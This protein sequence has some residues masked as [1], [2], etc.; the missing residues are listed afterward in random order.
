LNGSLSAALWQQQNEESLASLQLDQDCLLDDFAL[1]QM[2]Q[3]ADEGAPENVD[4]GI[5]RC[6]AAG[7]NVN[8]VRHF[9]KVR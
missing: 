8:H 4:G 7:C 9:C 2:M 1:A 6:R 3:A 5:R